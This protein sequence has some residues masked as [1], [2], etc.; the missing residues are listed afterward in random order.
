MPAAGI[1][2]R[3]AQDSL[4]T[5]EQAWAHGP[6]SARARP[7]SA[8][9]PVSGRL[10]LRTQAGQA[11][12]TAPPMSVTAQESGAQAAAVKRALPL[13]IRTPQPPAIAEQAATVPAKM[14]AAA[15][16]VAE[17]RGQAGQR[18]TMPDR[19]RTQTLS[20]AQA[21]TAE[22]INRPAGS[23][24]VGVPAPAFRIEVPARGRPVACLCSWPPAQ[25]AG[26]GELGRRLAFFHYR[27][28][29]GHRAGWEREGLDPVRSEPLPSSPTSVFSVLSVV[30]KLTIRPH[31]IARPVR[32]LIL[33]SRA[34][35]LC[36]HRVSPCRWRRAGRLHVRRARQRRCPR[37]RGP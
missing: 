1:R 20:M 15:A 4:P 16:R 28:H 10:P 25:P 9:R 6:T 26:A 8:S 31:W 22:W 37:R 35:A 5:R 2:P 7:C 17:P 13:R 27:D 3:P 30:K 36:L 24:A 21:R 14:M 29:R 11:A 34:H 19:A 23:R 18:A 12:T 33:R 32:G